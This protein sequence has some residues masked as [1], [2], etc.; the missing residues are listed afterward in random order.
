M[1]RKYQANQM[2]WRVVKEINGYWYEIK[3]AGTVIDRI[4][5]DNLTLEYLQQEGLV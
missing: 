2:L 4:P 1:A 3:L 5:I